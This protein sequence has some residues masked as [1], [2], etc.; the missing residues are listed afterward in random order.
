MTGSSLFYPSTTQ[1]TESADRQKN[2]QISRQNFKHWDSQKDTV[3]YHIQK[4]RKLDRQ[5]YRDTLRKKYLDRHAD[6][7]KDKHADRDKDENTDT[8][9]FKYR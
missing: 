6:I 9:I 7:L 8:Q 4:D 3:L 5:K 2:R 1:K